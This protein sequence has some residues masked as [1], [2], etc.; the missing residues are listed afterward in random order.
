MAVSPRPQPIA[1]PI[2]TRLRWLHALL[3]LLAAVLASLLAWG[4]PALAALTLPAP[5][6]AA[7]PG[8]VPPVPTEVR[9]ITGG[10]ILHDPGGRLI[11]AGL[12]GSQRQAAG[13]NRPSTGLPPELPGAPSDG[14][15]A[16]ALK[17]GA[18]QVKVTPP[19]LAQPW[20]VH[21]LPPGVPHM[22]YR[23]WVRATVDAMGVVSEATITKS[24]GDPKV[25]EASLRRLKRERLVP[26][27][28][29]LPDGTSSE[30]PYIGPI[31]IRW[32]TGG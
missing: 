27:R 23:G 17:V 14:S 30:V 3:G 10:S 32:V 31:F 7:G 16:A 6:P 20:L 22:V 18:P 24:T 12:P 13:A 9:S 1:A 5:G 19:D 2:A 26:A 29:V 25:D 8:E 15:G 21:E 4:I 28:K 11:Y